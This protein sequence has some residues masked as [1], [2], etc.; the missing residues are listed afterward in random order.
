MTVSIFSC[1]STSEFSDVRGSLHVIAF[2]ETLQKK[3]MLTIT[4]HASAEVMPQWS[5]LLY[6]KETVTQIKII[7]PLI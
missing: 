5:K 7:Y 1:L 2:S 4:F 3:S 6:L